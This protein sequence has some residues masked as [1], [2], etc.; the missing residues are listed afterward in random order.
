MQDG[1]ESVFG[2]E[3]V[4]RPI[5]V[6]RPRLPS[7][8]LL[9]PYLETLDD[10]RWYSNH[11]KLERML[12]ARL[13]ALLGS[14]E[15]VA[16][17]SSGTSALVGAILACA[18]RATTARPLCLCPAY[19][20]VATVA[21]VEQCGY[22]PYL[23]DIDE[24][25]W[26]VNPDGLADHPLLSRTGLVVPVAPYGRAVSQV[27]WLRFQKATGIP[28]VIDGAA[29]LESVVATPERNIGPLPVA[30]SFH[31]T[32]AFATGEGGAV[33]TSD[34]DILLRT[35]Q[36][37]NFGFMGAR[38]STIAGTNGKMSEYHAA[39]GLAELD[40]WTNKQGDFSR[41][42]IS[43]HHHATQHGLSNSV[44]T[45]PLIASCYAIFEASNAEEARFV[46]A[47]LSEER[48]EYRNWYGLG[49]HREPYLTQVE[50]DAL[51][52]VDG[53]APRLLGLPVAPDLT[54]P[55]IARIILAIARGRD[56]FNETS[57]Y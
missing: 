15:A 4:R 21:A 9:R 46:R 41:V 39:V 56:R 36:A 14:G 40:G 45:Q 55:E 23:I 19:T 18:G 5:Q 38:Q 47:A 54:S 51:P 30:L 25:D 2:E 52:G 31:A 33:V 49:L 35:N 44:V 16:M 29:S 10:S 53:L 57:S 32:K 20:F 42:A 43:Y 17:A 27:G 37:L 26:S 1:A 22:H 24:T 6:C 3:Q 12:A 11:G 28:V 50:R 8:E 48:I 7:F 13:S 34:A